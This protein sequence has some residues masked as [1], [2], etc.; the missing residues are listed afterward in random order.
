MEQTPQINRE[1]DIIATMT[2][3]A[4]T[5]V[6]DYDEFELLGDLGDSCVR[7]L[8]A[9]SAGVSLRDDS[10][11]EFVTATSET[12]E[13]IEL[14][15]IDREEGP[16]QDAFHTG[17]HVEAPD[18]DAVHDRWPRWTPRAIELGFRAADA[19][20]LRLR[21]DAIGALNV[22]SKRDRRLNEQDVALGRAFADIAT[23]GLL[24]QRAISE[25]ERVRDQ[26]QHALDSRV[27]IEQAKGIVAERHGLQMDQAFERIRT[28]SRSHNSRLATT[29]RDIVD[30]RLDPGAV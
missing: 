8:D 14:F 29:V 13:L 25:R 26:L 7:I 23:V 5:L 16:C 28:H 18:L 1:Q 11:L 9:D 6:T 12:M 22:Y 3:L 30:G 19:F 15:Q 2:R 17:R 27:V 21:D 20:P 10:R 4:D 24:Q